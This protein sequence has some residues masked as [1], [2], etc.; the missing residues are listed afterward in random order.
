LLQEPVARVDAPVKEEPNRRKSDV[1]LHPT[2]PA[3]HAETSL[4]YPRPT[5]E[6]LLDTT[7]TVADL[8]LNGTLAANSDQRVIVPHAGAALTVLA[9]RLAGLSAVLTVGGQ[10]PGELDVIGTLQKV[11][12]EVG[13]GFQFP[14]QLDALLDLVDASQLL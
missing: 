4:G 2:S 13:A 6:F 9:D 3:C 7:R 10:R 11:H 14:R 8:V 5:L 1:L 12:H